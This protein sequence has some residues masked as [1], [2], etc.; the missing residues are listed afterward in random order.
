MYRLYVKYYIYR[1]YVKVYN[2]SYNIIDLIFRHWRHKYKNVWEQSI[3]LHSTQYSNSIAGIH[4]EMLNNIKERGECD[5]SLN[6]L[7]PEGSVG[8]S[9][10]YC[11]TG[12]TRGEVGASSCIFSRFQ[13]SIWYRSI[14]VG[15]VSGIKLIRTDTTLWS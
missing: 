5:I 11:N 10:K 6:Y 12:P 14:P 7:L 1:L 4:N 8:R 15:Y 3:K 9:R 2:N 13:K